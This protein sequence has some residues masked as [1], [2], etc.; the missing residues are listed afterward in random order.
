MSIFSSLKNAL[1]PVNQLRVAYNVAKNPLDPFAQT[2]AL[3]TLFT[4]PRASS[5][6][7]GYGAPGPMYPPPPTA[8]YQPMPMGMTAP[9]GG[10]GPPQY[11]PADYAQPFVPAQY[12]PD[13]GWD[14]AYGGAPSD[15]QF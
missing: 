5:P 4:G 6:P 11:G 10:Y 9:P 12:G 2:R 1:N 3:T 13:T 14:A 15:D 8:P 7:P